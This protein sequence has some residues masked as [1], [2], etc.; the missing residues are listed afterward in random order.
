MS[1]AGRLTSSRTTFIASP[2]ICPRC[3]AASIL[4]PF[5]PDAGTAIT[6]PRSETAMARPCKSPDPRFPRPSRQRPMLW[7]R[8][9]ALRQFALDAVSGSF[10]G[11]GHSLHFFSETCPH[12]GQS[13]P[14]QTAEAVK[15][16]RLSLGRPTAIAL[17]ASGLASRIAS[18]SAMFAGEVARL[19]K[20]G[21]AAARGLVELGLDGRENSGSSGTPTISQSASIDCQGVVTRSDVH[22]RLRSGGDGSLGVEAAS[23]RSARFEFGAWNFAQFGL[24][25]PQVV[26]RQP[27]FSPLTRFSTSR[28]ADPPQ[29]TNSGIESTMPSVKFVSEKKTIEVPEGANLRQE[30]LKAGIELY[31]GIHRIFNCHGLRQC[32]SC[33]VKS[34]RGRT[35]SARRDFLTNACG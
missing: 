29:T 30:A 32:G 10:N 23:P 25:I 16:G 24:M 20:A 15:F 12:R 8:S 27:P 17:A 4:A 5:A 34:R 28:P 33:C 31:P 26:G 7:T 11:D 35:T 1:P 13:R 9:V 3:A 19:A 14:F 6:S 22:R 2:R 21:E 18:S